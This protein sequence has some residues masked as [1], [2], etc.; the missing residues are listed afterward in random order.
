MST[1]HIINLVVL[2][3]LLTSCSQYAVINSDDVEI[4]EDSAGHYFIQKALDNNWFAYVKPCENGAVS[5]EIIGEDN[6]I[7][8]LDKRSFCEVVGGI[9]NENSCLNNGKLIYISPEADGM[10]K[11]IYQLYQRGIMQSCD[12]WREAAESIELNSK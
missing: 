4:P 6:F 3:T 8:S 11:K 7:S 2:T 1:F 10:P 5:V 9:W 12:Q